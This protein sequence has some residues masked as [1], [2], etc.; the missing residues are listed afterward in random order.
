MSE[1]MG[2]FIKKSQPPEQ[3][4]IIASYTEASGFLGKQLTEKTYNQLEEK[5]DPANMHLLHLCC[6]TED[7]FTREDYTFHIEFGIALYKSGGV[8]CLRKCLQEKT[9]RVY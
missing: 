3:A 1:F 5:V 9:G 6:C 4:Y 7:E 2:E 8:V